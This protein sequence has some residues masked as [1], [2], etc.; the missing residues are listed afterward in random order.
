LLSEK[1]GHGGID[2]RLICAVTGGLAALRKIQ[3]P[4]S[5]GMGS[6]TE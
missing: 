4:F 6:R 2:L 1:I 5:L 3:T